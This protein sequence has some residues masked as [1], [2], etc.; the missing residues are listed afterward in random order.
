VLDIWYGLVTADDLLQQ[1]LEPEE[2][3]RV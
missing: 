2:L 1:V 3:E